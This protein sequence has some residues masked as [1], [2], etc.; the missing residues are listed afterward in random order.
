MLESDRVTDVCFLLAKFVQCQFEVTFDTFHKRLSYTISMLKKE[1]K[2]KKTKE[3]K[4]KR[5]IR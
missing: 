2:S 1:T 4:Q 3:T 5:N